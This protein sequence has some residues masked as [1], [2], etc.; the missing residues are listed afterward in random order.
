MEVADH[1]VKTGGVEM[2][3][4]LSGLDAVSDMQLSLTSFGEF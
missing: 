1:L 3:I 4:D 2:G